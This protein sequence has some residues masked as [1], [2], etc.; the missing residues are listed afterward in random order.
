MKELSRLMRPENKGEL[1]V[2][3]AEELARR[4]AQEGWKQGVLRGTAVGSATEL[5]P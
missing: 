2:L 3:M 4:N 1:S 5:A